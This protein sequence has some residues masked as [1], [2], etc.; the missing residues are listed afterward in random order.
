[1][2]EPPPTRICP[3][4]G[5]RARLDYPRCPY[6][7]T[8]FGTGERPPMGKDGVAAT[9][10][11]LVGCSLTAVI[12][13]FVGALFT[14][15]G[16]MLLAGSHYPPDV[17]ASSLFWRSHGFWLGFLL[18]V[19]LTGLPYLLLRRRFPAFARGLGYSCLVAVAM[20]LGAPLL[21]SR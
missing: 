2:P 1:M 21:C 14:I 8:D 3:R 12:Y 17:R 4:C 20:T 6:C 11:T 9:G 18:P 10:G 19:A 16:N 13:L 15:S 5:E 7:G